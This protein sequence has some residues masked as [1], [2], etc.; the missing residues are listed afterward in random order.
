MPEKQVTLYCTSQAFIGAKLVKRGAAVEVLESE[1]KK[2]LG[3]NRFSTEKPGVAKK[4]APAKS[5]DDGK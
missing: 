3:S 5:A 1:A 4:T 2:L